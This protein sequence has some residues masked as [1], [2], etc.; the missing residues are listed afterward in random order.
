MI[1]TVYVSLDS[2]DTTHLV[3]VVRVTEKRDSITSVF[4]YDPSYLASPDSYPLDPSLPLVSGNQ[5][6]R[7]GLPG[8]LRDASPD[9]WGRNLIRKNLQAGDR[10]RT[11]RHIGELDYLL[12]VSDATRQGALRV[13]TEP[14]GPYVDDSSVVPPLIDLGRLRNA[15]RKISVGDDVEGVKELLRAGTASLGG[16]R[17]KAAV[18]DGDR[19]LLAKFSHA[20]DDYDQVGAECVAL[21]LAELAGIDTPWHD[22]L[23]LDDDRALVVERFDRRASTRVGYISAMTLTGLTDGDTMD[24]L[25]IAD[26]IKNHGSNT[27]HDVH[28]LWRRMLFSIGVNNLDDHGRNH[29][30]LRDGAGWSLAPVFDLTPDPTGHLRATLMAGASHTDDCFAALPD[31]AAAWDISP[32]R[33]QAIAS[34]VASAL[35]Q[36]SARASARHV[37]GPAISQLGRISADRAEHIRHTWPTI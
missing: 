21:D 32:E 20:T 17:P 26:G 23:V 6:I 3:G 14:M 1:D 4:S 27:S 13:S 15:A 35:H 34:D 36:W 16:A 7:G 8:A 31:I 29:G 24:Y 37:T 10:E 25:Q 5:V 18:T 2:H 12:G 28:A 9:R 22:L 33:Q 11:G 30:F 19:L